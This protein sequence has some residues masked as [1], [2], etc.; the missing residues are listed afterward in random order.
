MVVGVRGREE[1]KTCL[2]KGVI[3]YA[4][5]VERA[6]G[7]PADPTVEYTRAD[8]THVLHN[9][10]DTLEAYALQVLALAKEL[11]VPVVNPPATEVAPRAAPE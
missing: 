5:W 11:G 1:L 9:P 2:A 6:G 3:K 10:G 4:V 7:V 8:C